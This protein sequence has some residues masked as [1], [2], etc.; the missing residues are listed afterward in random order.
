M[1]KKIAGTLLMLFSLNGLFAQS[2]AVSVDSLKGQYKG[3]CKNGKADGIGTATG[4]DTYTGSFKNGYPDGEGKYSWKNGSWYEGQWKKGLFDGKGTLSKIDESKKDSLIIVS[5]FWK[6]GK[7]TGAVEK[8]Y[9]ITAITN[10]FNN[11]SFRKLNNTQS[12]ISIVVKCITSGASDVANVHLPKPKLVSMETLK[13]RFQQ[14]VTDESSSLISNSY[15][16]RQ[17][18]FPFHAVFSFETPSMYQN[19]HVEKIEVEI[20]ETGNW[21][22]QLNIDN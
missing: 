9:T 15:T 12:E 17:V 14:Q 10:N 20:L 11:I 13:G 2:C 18:S 21:Y 3:D 22:M 6:K 8:P 7:Y 5:G 4:T 16:F 19:L 1:M